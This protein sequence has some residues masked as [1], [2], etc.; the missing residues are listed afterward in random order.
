[1]KRLLKHLA[2]IFLVLAE[3]W[4]CVLRGMHCH[5]GVLPFGP[6][7][8]FLVSGFTC[9]AGIAWYLESISRFESVYHR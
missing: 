4:T 1:M 5:V 7:V 2:G 9:Y 3:V 6:V 8:G